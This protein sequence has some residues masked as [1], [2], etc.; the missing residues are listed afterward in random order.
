MDRKEKAPL[1][2]GRK[3]DRL[4]KL[5]PRSMQ[6]FQ[7]EPNK[8]RMEMGSR[9][10]FG[11]RAESRFSHGEYDH[12]ATHHDAQRSQVPRSILRW[13]RGRRIPKRKTLS[14]FLHEY[15]SQNERF[16]DHT[17]FQKFYK[18]QVEESKKQDADRFL[19]STFAGSPTCLAG[20]WVKELDSYL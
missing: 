4:T 9:E 18:I 6:C 14:E 10:K 2:E 3:E 1:C 19:L 7:G 13:M 8:I 15:E 11:S 12:V 20:A 16:R 17:N 5:L